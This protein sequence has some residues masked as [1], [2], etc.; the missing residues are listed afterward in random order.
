MFFFVKFNRVL[1]LFPGFHSHLLGHLEIQ[2]LY[3]TCSS[4]AL[5]NP[6]TVY[7]VYWVRV[8]SIIF[9]SL[10][11][12]QPTY[13][14]SISTN[15]YSHFQQSIFNILISIY[16]YSYFHQSIFSFPQI[17]MLISIALPALWKSWAKLSDGLGSQQLTPEIKGFIVNN[18]NVDIFILDA[19][20]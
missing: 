10:G 12:F 1:N 17:N 15:Q 5:F 14:H 18:G 8:F 9:R 6:Y 20:L 13:T 11:F 7:W 19:I 3:L 2:H 4:L 16:Q